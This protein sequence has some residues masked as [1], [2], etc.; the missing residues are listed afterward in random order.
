MNTNKKAMVITDTVKTKKK[1]IVIDDD[2]LV[3]RIIAKMLSE[4]GV[5]PLEIT[6]GT[7]ADAILRKEGGNLAMAIVDLVLPDGPTG[8]DLI[9]IIRKNA[10]TSKM[11]VVVIT[12]AQISS[13]E[14]T[15]L[16]EKADSVICKKDFSI[17]N[18]AGILDDLLGVKKR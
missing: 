2:L 6:N 4:R 14:I 12:G 8:W 9:D 5:E 15:R 1:A 7:D 17:D 13:D 11:P 18:F 10:D 16:K 3:C